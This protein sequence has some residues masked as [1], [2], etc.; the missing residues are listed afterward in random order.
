VA[1]EAFPPASIG[2]SWL[3]SGSDSDS[4]SERAGKTCE[5]RSNVTV[6]CV[7]AGG[8][9]VEEPAR[10]DVRELVGEEGVLV[11][12]CSLGGGRD[13]GR[14]PEVS[15][16]CLT[17]SSIRMPDDKQPRQCTDNLSAELHQKGMARGRD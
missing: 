7:G 15:T 2:V 4:V 13:G 8:G 17:C 5:D 11:P 9:G 1:T 12:D 3:V 10:E 16:R 6:C 14:W